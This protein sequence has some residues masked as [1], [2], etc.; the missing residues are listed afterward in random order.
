MNKKDM[1]VYDSKNDEFGHFKDAR[2]QYRTKFQLEL[3][4]GYD[5]ILD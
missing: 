5:E 3:C 4:P 2:C 1:M